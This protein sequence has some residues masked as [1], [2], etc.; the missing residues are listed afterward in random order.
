MVINITAKG[1]NYDIIIENGLLSK[2]HMLEAFKGKSLIVTDSG[3]PSEYSEKVSSFCS[4]PFR[5]II[6]EGEKSKSLQSFEAIVSFMQEHSFDRHDRIIA[7]GGGVVGDLSGFVA[8][9][10]MRG[11]TFINVPTTLLSMTDSSVGGKTAVDFNGTKNLI[12]AFYQ[13]SLVLIDPEVLATLPARQVASGYAEIIKMSLTFSKEL[14][15]KLESP[16]KN[17]LDSVLHFISEGI[18]IKKSVVEADPYESGL[19]KVLNFGHTLGHA[20]ESNENGSLFHGEA[21]ALG[22]L[23]MCSEEVRSRL[24]AMYKFYGLPTDLDKYTKDTSALR[25]FLNNDKKGNSG[26]IDCIY[27]ETPG[28]YIIKKLRSEEII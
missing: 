8:S 7:V 28:S 21:V 25:T 6:P 27:V 26:L 1:D 17:V 18:L 12:G 2:L 14:F 23:R 24:I 5:Y 19:R 13:P 3:V 16:G 22:M 9:A 4:N 15:E 11:I 20:I 10:Y